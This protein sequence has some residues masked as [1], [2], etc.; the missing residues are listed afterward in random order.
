MLHLQ[1]EDAYGTYFVDWHEYY[2]SYYII[3]V[4]CVEQLWYNVSTQ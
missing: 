4:K 3:H 1:S 2:V